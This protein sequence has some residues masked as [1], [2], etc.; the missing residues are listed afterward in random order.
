[1]VID[2][3]TVASGLDEERATATPNAGAGPLST[4]VPVKFLPP[5]TNVGLSR[6]ADGDG[7]G[8]TTRDPVTLILPAAS[9]SAL[10][11]ALTMART[12]EPTGVVDA[13]KV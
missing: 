7:A 8:S 11:D 6:T 13:V 10:A 2:A 9:R 12:L 4:T 1:M 5:I 3:G